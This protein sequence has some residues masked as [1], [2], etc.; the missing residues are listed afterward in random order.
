MTASP[1]RTLSTSPDLAVASLR[2]ELAWYRELFEEAPDAYLVT[3]LD[4][5][6]ELANRRAGELLEM[7]AGELAGRS[8]AGFLAE[9]EHPGFEET[10][11]GLGR[12]TAVLQQ[13]I[14]LTLRPGR[15]VHAT[16]SA[17]PVLDARG[18]AAG[19]RWILR[20]LDQRTL[21]ALDASLQAEIRERRRAEDQ[22]LALAAKLSR[23]N[24]ELEDF[25]A[26]AAHDLQEPLRKI[27]VYGNRLND[28]WQADAHEQGEEYLSR[29]LD[30]AR[31]MQSLVRDLFAYARVTTSGQPMDRVDL[32]RVAR[33]VLA[34]L[35]VLIEQSGGRVAVHELPAIE[36]DPRQMRQLF[37]NLLGNA[38][39]FHRTGEPP[40]VE[41]WA[42]TTETMGGGVRLFFKDN[43]IGFDP[44]HLPRI[45]S[46][47]H[48]LHSREEYPGTG[49]GLAI[50]RKI[51][52][53]HGGDITATSAQGR[54]ATFV[55]SLPIEQPRRAP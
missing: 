22:L 30:A 28:A 17:T 1:R 35:E 53:G 40:V 43:G 9:G 34:D 50:C 36:A 37:Q 4:G 25:A 51:A 10:L 44:R 18:A 29:I 27:V 45:F 55:V 14:R 32:N 26:V 48:R 21:D 24:R 52:Q 12:G 8:L 31:R 39:K 42:E 13:A 38:L 2:A 41:V 23:S 46:I 54:G 16:I 20:G 6:I 11:Q 15:Q 49:V 7:P 47:F 33:E 3:S 19:A 5:T